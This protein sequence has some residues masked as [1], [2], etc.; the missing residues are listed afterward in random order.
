M[1][2]VAMTAK[3]IRK[4]LKQKFPNIKFSVRS[5]S[6]AGGDNVS[7]SYDDSV[8][9]NEIEAIVKKYKCGHFDGMTDTYE[10][11][12]TRDDIP[13]ARFVFVDRR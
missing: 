2:T 4:E 1:T 12:N 3:A 9:Q 7:I 8:P 10:Y 6:Y 5:E 11:S 13:Q